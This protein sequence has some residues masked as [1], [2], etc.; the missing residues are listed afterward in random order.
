MINTSGAVDFSS[1]DV[2]VVVPF[3]PCVEFRLGDIC[4][5][6]CFNDVVEISQCRVVCSGSSTYLHFLTICQ[7]DGTVVD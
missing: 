5:C 7:G 6:G 2:F 4:T 3:S 1:C